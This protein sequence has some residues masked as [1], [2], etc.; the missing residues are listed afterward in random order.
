MQALT[1]ALCFALAQAGSGPIAPPPP[2]PPSAVAPVG[3]GEPARPPRFRGGFE[4]TV[5]SF[6]SGPR[7]GGQDLFAAGV[8]LLSFDGGEDFALEL[9]ALLRLR[10]F[11]DPP[12]QRDGDFGRIL[13]RE[14]WDQLSDFGQVLRHLRVGAEGSVF[15][16]RAGAFHAYTLGNGQLISRYSNQLNPDYHPAGGQAVLRTGPVR[17]EVF[18]S[19]VLGGRLFASEVAMD[20]GRAFGGASA[21]HER[22]HLAL[23]A[24]HDFARAGGTSPSFSLAWL[25]VESALLRG[26]RARINAYLGGGGRVQDDAVSLGATLGMS[27]EAEADGMRLGGRLEGRRQNSGFRQGMVGHD[28]ELARFSGVGL[29]RAPVAEERLPAGFSAYGELS[30]ALG[31]EDR[32]AL[33]PAAFVFTGAVEHFF[34]GRINLD[35]AFSG[36]A[37]EG[38]GALAMRFSGVGLGDMPRYLLGTELRYR[39]LPS[40]YLVGAGG[41]VFLPQPEGGLH[42]GMFI[43]LG[44]GVDFER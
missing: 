41:T 43:A 33:Q 31:A 21:H 27:G 34:F 7:G 26:P 22:Y 38:R 6:P 15:A 16:L 36:Q 39:V 3:P 25:E 44:A 35:A 10:L 13:R 23:S 29:W 42:R 1:L 20:L 9:G 28:Y 40:V 18:A 12:H 19:D 17:T 14:D 32:N 24:L 37:L 8:P 30:W 11:D 2:P 4:L 5:L